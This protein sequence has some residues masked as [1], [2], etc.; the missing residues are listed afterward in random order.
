MNRKYQ[1]TILGTIISLVSIFLPVAFSAQHDKISIQYINSP[2]NT[3][4]E[5]SSQGTPLAYIYSTNAAPYEITDTHFYIDTYYIENRL[6]YRLNASKTF[7]I[8]YEASQPGFTYT[9]TV[10]DSGGFSKI[11][12]MIGDVNE[13]PL[14]QP[15]A[16]DL[17]ENTAAGTTVFQVVASDPDFY[18]DY[19]TLTYSIVGGSGSNALTIDRL[20]GAI[21]IKNSTDLNYEANRYLY[22]TVAVSDGKFEDV[23]TLTIHLINI[24]DNAP[25]VSNQTFSVGKYVPFGTLVSTVVAQ[26][27]DGNDL[28]YRLTSGNTNYAFAIDASSGKM[29]VN[30][31]GQIANSSTG[32]YYVTVAVSDSGYTKTAQIRVDVNTINY[33]PVI[34]PIDDQI[35]T[36]NTARDFGFH[37]EDSNGESLLVSVVSLTTS[38]VPNT[39]NNLKINQSNS[40]YSLVVLEG[41]QDLTLT[42][43]PGNSVGTAT[44][45]ITV[46]DNSTGELT[47]SEFFTLQVLPNTPPTITPIET[48]AFDIDNVVYSTSFTVSDSI[49]ESVSIVVGSSLSDVVPNTDE[50]IAVGNN[51][52]NASFVA[53]DT[54]KTFTL[55]LTPVIMGNTSIQITAID[56]GGLET[57]ETF[58]LRVSSSPEIS[59]I[60]SQETNEDILTSSIP[61]TIRTH[62]PGPLTLSIQTGNADLIPA[63]ADHVTICFDT[64]CTGGATQVINTAG[65]IQEAV[66]LFLLPKHDQNG[67]VTIT[68]SAI[69]GNGLI[70]TS[71]FTTT[72]H[73]VNDAPVFSSVGNAIAYTEGDSPKILIPAPVLQDVDD[74]HLENATVVI[75]ENYQSGADIL[76]F[77]ATER[78]SGLFFSE[79]GTLQLTGMDTLSAYQAAFQSITYSN[80]SDD[81]SPLP[82]T[83]SMT[84]NDGDTNSAVMTQSLTLTAINDPPVLSATTKIITCSENTPIAI[85][86]DILVIDPD[87][88]QLA[89]AVINFVEGYQSTEDM[90]V[91][92]N[93]GSI[94]SLWQTATG[95]LSLS[96][97][98]SLAHYQIALK[99]IQY[100]NTSDTPSTYT[101]LVRMVI[102]DGSAQSS[103]ITQ[104]LFVEPVND[105]P[106]VTGAG[107]SVTY[108]EN[109]APL[110]VANDISIVDMDDINLI[111]ATIYIFDGFQKGA[112]ILSLG[113]SGSYSR[114]FPESG[115]LDI[116][117]DRPKAWYQAA[118]NTVEYHNTSDDPTSDNRLIAFIVNDGQDS[119]EVIYQTIKVVPINDPPV[120]LADT[121][122]LPYTENSTVSMADALTI[123]DLDNEHLQQLVA[124]ISKGYSPIEDQLSFLP[125]GTISSTWNAQ[126]GTLT[127]TGADTLFIYRQAFNQI[128]YKNLSDNPSLHLRSVSFKIFDGQAWSQSITRTVQIIPVND[129]PVVSIDE[130]HTYT[131]NTGAMPIAQSFSMT[132]IDSLT[133]TQL[134]IQITDNYTSTQDRLSVDF[135]AMIQSTWNADS[136]TLSLTG[137]R[138]LS[139]Y[140]DI[141]HTLTYENYSDYPRPLNRQMRYQAWDD[142]DAS[143]PVLQT[144]T[145]IPIND[146]PV[147]SGGS[148]TESITENHMGPVFYTIQA[149][150]V[151]N[152]LIAG[153]TMTLTGGYHSDEDRLSFENTVLITSSWNSD[154][155]QLQLSGLASPTSYQKALNAVQYENL[156]DNPKTNLRTVSVTLTDG[157]LESN[158][159][160]GTLQIIP[161][162]DR[163]VLSGAKSYSYTENSQLVFNRSLGIS[164]PDSLTMTKAVI[165]IVQNYQADEDIL[166]L[167]PVGNITGVFNAETGEFTLTG[168]DTIDQFISAL[169]KTTYENISDHPD[170]S[171][172]TL[173]IRIHDGVDES[174]AITETITIIPVNDP[175]VINLA[176]TSFQY[177]EN[178]GNHVLNS[179]IQLVDPD[180]TTFSSAVVQF[181]KNTYTAGE[182]HLVY[183]ITG[184]I[185][186]TWNID[187]GI[188]T[189]SGVETQAN[190]QTVLSKIA[191]INDNENPENHARSIQWIISD[192][193][194]ESTPVT[195]TIQV[196][197]V[198]D[199]PVLTGGGGALDYSENTSLT[200]ANNIQ[201]EDVDNTTI[202]RATIMIADGYVQSE[203]VLIFPE[204]ATTGNIISGEMITGTSVM[205]LTG[206]DTLLNYQAALRLVQYFNLSD[207]PQ[208]HDRR[209][210]FSVNDGGGTQSSQEVERIIHIVKVNDAPHL[211]VNT[212]VTINEGDSITL[213]NAHLSATDPDDPDEGLFY[214]IDGLPEHGTLLIDAIPLASGVTLIQGNIDNGRISYHH[215][216]GESVMDVFSFHITDAN[217]AVTEPKYF[218]ITIIPVNDS[219]QITS[220]PIET[221][222]E[223]ILYAYTVTVSDPDDGVNGADIFFQLQNEPEGMTISTLGIISWIP[224]EGVLTSGMVTISVQD[225]GENDSVAAV[226]SFSVAVT[227]VEDPPQLSA[228]DDL[229]TYGNTQTPP[230]SFQVFDA[231]GG[232]L[233]LN[234]FSTNQTVAPSQMVLFQDQTSDQI[235]VDLPGETFMEYSLT[236]MPAYNQYGSVTVTV[237]A[238]DSTGLTGVTSFVLLVDKVTITVQ[239]RIHGQIIPGHP[240]KVKKGQW[241][242]FRIDPDTGYRIDDVWIDGI[243]AGPIPTYTFWSVTEPHTIS[244]RFAESSVCTITTLSTNGGSI[245]PYGVIPITSGDQP[246]FHIIPNET[247]AIEDVQVDGISVGPVEWYTFSPLETVHTIR[248]LFRYVPEPVASF[249]YDLTTGQVPLN[250]QFQ[251][252]SR[253]QITQWEWDFG[254]GFHSTAHHPKHAYMNAGQYSVSLTVSGKGGQSQTIKT[255]VINVLSANV[256]FSAPIRTGLAPLSVSFVNL[257]VLNNVD[258]WE[259]TFGDSQTSTDEQPAHLYTTPGLYTVSLTAMI[260]ESSSFIGKKQYIHVLGRMIQG[261]V[262]DDTTGSELSNIQVE[263]WQDDRLFMETQ[264]NALGAY[265]FTGLPVADGWRVS[266]WPDHPEQYLPMYYDGQITMNSATSLT[267][268]NSNLEN[269]DFLMIAAPK[270]GIKGRVHDGRFNPVGTR[271]QVSVFSEKLNMGRSQMTDENGYYT[272][273]GLLPSD[274]YRV[275]A[276]STTCGCEFFYYMEPDQ[277]IGFDLPVRSARTWRT[278]TPVSSATPLTQ[279]IDIIIDSGGT[280]DGHVKNDTGE[281][282]ANVWVNAWSDLLEI[283]NG[284]YTD[285]NGDYQIKCLRAES[286]SGDV[287]YRVQV[288]PPD[289]PIMMYNQVN[290]LDMATPVVIDSQGIDFEFHK[291][292]SIK[293]VVRDENGMVMQNI[294]VRAWSEAFAFTA[295]AQ[296]VTNVNGQY[297][298]ANLQLQSDYIVAVFPDY[299]PVYYYPASRSI[300]TAMRID[301]SLEN[302]TGIDFQLDPGAVI[303]GIVY[304]ENKNTPGPM[305]LFVNIWSDST[306]TGGEVPLDANGRF[307]MT[308]LRADICDYII[309]IHHPQFIPAYYGAS[310][311]HDWQLS[312]ETA[313]PVCCSPTIERELILIKGYQ[314]K[315]TIVYNN[316]PV[317]DAF[318]QAWSSGS[319]TWAE[320]TSFSGGETDNFILTGLAKGTYEISVSAAGFSDKT[321]KNIGIHGDVT[322]LIIEL[323]RPEYLISGIVYGL[324]TGKSVQINA[325]AQSIQNGH[326]IRLTG[327]GKPLSYTIT[328]LETAID[329]RIELWSM[330]YPYQVYPNGRHFSD[331]ENVLV[332]G[333]VTDIDFSLS[334]NETGEL[335][336][337]I[338]PWPGVQPGDVVFV[339]AVSQ[340]LGTSKNA[341]IVFEST[342]A[343]SYQLKGL[344]FTNDYIVSAWS[345]LAPMMY[346]QQTFHLNEAQPVSVSEIPTTDVHFNLSDGLIIS[347]TLYN[348]STQPAA[349]V[350]VS[351]NSQTYNI[352]QSALTGANGYYEIKGLIPA[353]DYQVIAQGQDMPAVYYQTK[354]N[355]VV[356]P[357]FASQVNLL[358]ASADQIDIHIPSGE[359]ICGFVRDTDGQAIQFAW[360][361]VQSDIT[362]ASNDT[363]SDVHGNFCVKCL[364]ESV[365]Y[366]LTITPPAP[367]VTNVRSMIATGTL[368]MKCTVDIG[369]ELSGSIKA[370]NGTAL[371]MVDISVWSSSHDFHAWG[372][373][374]STG[375]FT[376]QG[377]PQSQDLFLTADPTDDQNIA[378]YIDGPFSVTTNIEKHIILGSAIEIKGHIK[379][380][381]SGEGLKDALITAYS[382]DLHTDAQT[383]SSSNGSFVF[384]HLP[385]AHDYLLT[386]THPQYA[387]RTLPFADAQDDMIV[388]LEPGSSI[389]GHVQ[390]D[391]GMPLTNIRIDIQSNDQRFESSVRSDGKGDFVITGLPMTGNTYHL[392]AYNQELGYAPVTSAAQSAGS[393]VVFLMIKDAANT[394]QGTI[395][396]SQASPPPSTA[397]ITVRL[398]D[399]DGIFVQK[400][401]AD[402]T[403]NFKFSGLSAGKSYKIKCSVSEDRLIDRIQWVG[404]MGKGTLN[405]AEAIDYLAGKT[406][407]ILLSGT[408]R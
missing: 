247:Y 390:D 289:Y 352:Y 260:D 338:T 19:N 397:Q 267:T 232:P 304:E 219:P 2:A 270:S 218:T 263:L 44:I 377:I 152:P 122:T 299:Y 136:G 59:A 62:E 4:P 124:Q 170:D 313:Q 146:A 176:Q 292:L 49:G 212:G 16:F 58:L 189:F 366:Q 98:A 257:S 162:N 275:S 371:S 208:N 45:Q 269:I 272:L 55:K 265:T 308:G 30:N 40:P 282:L 171:L 335:S 138:P 196:I 145:L 157:S 321:L 209:I 228:I 118:L 183:T 326:M 120:L 351:A 279:R 251:D 29:T 83:F 20:T 167:T 254:D 268:R 142:T 1:F 372:Q 243:S 380:K 388:M 150:D 173:T 229:L 106:V 123:S 396:D 147:L 5:N 158:M 114:W 283:G 365:D 70:D 217:N 42:V 47:A 221:G 404:P 15:Q 159:I 293:G 250:I 43:L 401:P 101:R 389:T 249:S 312:W 369:Y 309:S 342:E 253:G 220:L 318:I 399:S 355:S 134:T 244:A 96:G 79:T 112:D 168:P 238:T 132:D 156:S 153:A 133:T 287:T 188:L 61:F 31:A 310:S 271:V 386:V 357:V 359:S 361:S 306:Q 245:E 6:Q 252:Q 213:T 97:A 387:T 107:S 261:T 185:Q 356:N 51:G 144:L 186:G 226:Q 370:Y 140:I 22:L 84:I 274:D 300:D 103:A 80:T 234:V 194:A 235:N 88:A 57:V 169:S 129:A 322:D 121:L 256:D 337:I 266:V 334:K 54:P 349:G 202:S 325:W 246:V 65:G 316:Q 295:Y 302:V 155:G 346:Y 135:S 195:Q 163:P 166:S 10:Y 93:M 288:N 363:F 403:G 126:S 28:T 406:V 172:R 184:D 18:T 398:F 248:P 273:L 319:G 25:Q 151:D 215:D 74:T 192:G 224:K 320:T 198:N 177:T 327:D 353:S 408:W 307:E 314:L 239:H 364:P 373:S 34:D 116:S 179:A 109:N 201:I 86:P 127:L 297:T 77:E 358:T 368:E 255:N 214:T 91:F 81:P 73:P 294:P 148:T 48:Q 161:V 99:S 94:T 33:S 381:S 343:V 330:D 160:T 46:K 125:V 38:I 236:I 216:G 285:D 339:D 17:T 119:S 143:T 78:I 329:Y 108:T 113:I 374:N 56:A 262:T 149:S 382:S 52:R 241:I 64:V 187:T 190:Y 347:G 296:T 331:A 290:Q 92:S 301:L 367:Y 305:G 407:H 383:R 242:H 67:I 14:I 233:T 344:A 328:N 53:T 32:S 27:P 354:D 211:P 222:I 230:I 104:T 345:T 203:D 50:H 66:Q 394:L 36:V 278:A 291:G 110:I 24:N 281:P 286:L 41:S 82:R 341:R 237:L 340:T 204:N 197:P 164:D 3:I 102:S 402:T 207:D 193:T 200:I 276:W 131:E 324:E 231:E 130:S 137:A 205:I 393:H 323:E 72:I 284:T 128:H 69:D 13:S 90:L 63:D 362:G 227:P 87:N 311:I 26:D 315:G 182:D 395:T 298:L 277:A 117:G 223:D 35:G 9:L 280:L 105:H 175:P 165:T 240:A 332:Q 191:Y 174:L 391:S 303:R 39:N 23:A 181:I 8:D 385:D 336:G 60:G 348:S 76:F 376:I 12:M 258:Q 95:T 360:I 11:P 259:W 317:S 154:I 111:S 100:K 225:G 199:P 350:L 139:D 400:M 75:S 141:V 37:V 206:N 21:R 264:T 384:N 210:T 333:A 378:R 115:V 405:Y 71:T 68:V 375:N 85:A 178:E 180:N 89:N 379:I 7:A 392:S